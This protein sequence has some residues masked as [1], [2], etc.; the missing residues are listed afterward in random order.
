MWTWFNARARP[1]PWF[2]ITDE[3]ETG[4]SQALARG[5]DAFSGDMCRVKIAERILRALSH[6]LDRQWRLSQRILCGILDE[7][8]GDLAWLLS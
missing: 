4:P 3:A 7:S 6:H 5:R 2:C 8:R 1:T